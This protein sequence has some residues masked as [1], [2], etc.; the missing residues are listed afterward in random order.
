MCGRLN[1]RRIW[2]KNQECPLCKTIST[3]LILPEWH[4]RAH[5]EAA[6]PIGTLFRLDD[7]GHQ[8]KTGLHQMAVRDETTGLTFV[9]Y[10]LAE[11]PMPIIAELHRVAPSDRRKTRNKTAAPKMLEVPPPETTSSPNTPIFAPNPTPDASA[12]NVNTETRPRLIKDGTH[13]DGGKL[14]RQRDPGGSRA[15]F[16]ENTRMLFMHITCPQHSAGLGPVDQI[17]SKFA[18]DVQMERQDNNTS[19]RTGASALSCHYTYLAGCGT[20]VM[21]TSSPAVD[22]KEVPACVYDAH[23]VLVDYQTHTVFD[24]NKT[25]R[26]FNQSIY[27]MGN[28]ATGTSSFRITHRAQDGPVGYM[29]FGASCSIE[30]LIGD[31]DNRKR[32]TKGGAA[33]RAEILLGHGDAL[34]TMPVEDD[35]PLEVRVKR[36]GLAVAETAQA[37]ARK[38]RLPVLKQSATP[39]KRQVTPAKRKARTPSVKHSKP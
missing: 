29:V 22:W 16:S 36:T 24:D 1:P 9:E 35:A 30:I 10:W 3:A 21:H 6:G 5:T 13:P 37:V 4:R 2:S 27:I 19:Y 31:G 18:T 20:H 32:T 38:E 39:A 23:S 15:V 26:E 12:P 25:I 33:R 11:A 14:I 34:M 28:G 17:F 8:P 7:G